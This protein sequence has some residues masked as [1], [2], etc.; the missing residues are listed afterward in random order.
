MLQCPSSSSRS[1]VA[2]SLFRALVYCLR[3]RFLHAIVL[4]GALLPLALALPMFF[5][6]HK[7][8][9]KDREDVTPDDSQTYLQSCFR[10]RLY[11]RMTTT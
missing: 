9:E 6:C 4:Y 7:T 5:L 8:K 10:C 1:A 2:K 3:R 11:S